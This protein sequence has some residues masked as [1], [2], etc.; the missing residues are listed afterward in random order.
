MKIPR[1][2]CTVTLLSK[3]L[4]LIVVI[5]LPIL[6]FMLGRLYQ[7]RTEMSN[8]TPIIPVMVTNTVMN[9]N[10]EMS[11][12]SAD[13]GRWKTYK[14]NVW[15]ISFNY[16]SS[17]KLTEQANS[18]VIYSPGSTTYNANEDLK[19][20][21]YLEPTKA[22]DSLT[23]VTEDEKK[24]GSK[25]LKEEQVDINGMGAIRWEWQGLGDGETYFVIHNNQ[26]I[27]IAKYP[28]KTSRQSEFNQILSTF[29]FISN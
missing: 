29:K 23:Q 20:E 15:K 5:F 17:Y 26:R 2:L 18:L 9:V 24:K 13:M 22:N 28:L 3:A 12:P 4:A 1:E 8:I 19:V 11:T 14:N 6:G 25:P 21:I 7:I 16:P 27:H 10:D